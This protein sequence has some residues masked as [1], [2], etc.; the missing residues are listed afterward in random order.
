MNQP[1]HLA[2][3]LAFGLAAC[4]FFASYCRRAWLPLMLVG[5]VLLLGMVLTFSRISWLHIVIVGGLAGLLWTKDQR[6]VRRWLL[7][8]APLVLLAVV[9]QLLDGLVAHANLLWHWGLPGS[10]GDR[11]QEGRG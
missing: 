5:L 3:Y 11:M 4:A 8:C 10:V 6:G 2:S 1:N 7:A 9:Y